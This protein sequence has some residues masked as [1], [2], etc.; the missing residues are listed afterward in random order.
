MVHGAP[1]A[2]TV[3][4]GAPSAQTVVH[5]APSGQ[6]HFQ[7]LPFNIGK[8]T[9]NEASFIA[10]F[11]MSIF[12]LHQMLYDKYSYDIREKSVTS[13]DLLRA[14]KINSPRVIC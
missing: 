7:H 9:N 4:H 14:F 11:I 1:S 2:K 10:R 6:S 13:V 3:V 12:R 8:I 5:G